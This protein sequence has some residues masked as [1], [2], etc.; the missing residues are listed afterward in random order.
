[1]SGFHATAEYG[2]VDFSVGIEGTQCMPIVNFI[3]YFHTLNIMYS[4][5]VCK[6]IK[7]LPAHSFYG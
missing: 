2:S 3:K 4:F 5:T 7:R 6:K 1:M